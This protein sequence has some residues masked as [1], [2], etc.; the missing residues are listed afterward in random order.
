MVKNTKFNKTFLGH[1]QI[2]LTNDIVF[3]LVY[4]AGTKESN[5]ALVALLNVVLERGNDPIAGVKVANTVHKG[6]RPGD[7]ETVMDIKARS[8]AGEQFNVEMQASVQPSYGERTLAYGA[9]MVNS[10]LAKGEDYATM[11]KSIVIS[12]IDGVM[13][14]STP[15]F[16]TE[17]GLRDSSGGLLL[18]DRLE[19]HFLELGKIDGSKEPGGMAPLERFCAYLKFAGDHRKEGYVDKL[20]DTGEEAILMSDQVFRDVTEDESL[21]DLLWR[22]E[23]AEHDLATKLRLAEKD[24]ERLGIEQGI[25]RGIAAFVQDYAED[26]RPCEVIIEKLRLRFGLDQEAARQYYEKYGKA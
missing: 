7:K 2:P 3:F 13:F 19:V 17:F 20:L 4:G 26:G 23:V 9:R 16:H 18:T 1:G 5:R 15:R 6:F 10:S 8:Q 21:Q 12:F 24:G 14:K 11:K 25:E 22:R